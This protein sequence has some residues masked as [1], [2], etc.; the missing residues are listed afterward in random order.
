MKN[1]NNLKNIQTKKSSH[2][3]ENKKDKMTDL[4]NAY[5]VW[6]EKVELWKSNQNE[7]K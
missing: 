1:F 6:L 7:N 5:R 3:N 4:E 2:I